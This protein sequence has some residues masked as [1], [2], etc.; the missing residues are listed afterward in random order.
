MLSYHTLVLDTVQVERHTV[1][2]LDKGLPRSLPSCLPFPP[3]VVTCRPFSTKSVQPFC[4]RT[5]PS[6]PRFIEVEITYGIEEIKSS[7]AEE[8]SFSEEHNEDIG[9]TQDQGDG[10]DECCSGQPLLRMSQ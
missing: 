5:Y 9:F 6:V 3:V 4:N 8:E 2:N 10:S 1:L 7:R